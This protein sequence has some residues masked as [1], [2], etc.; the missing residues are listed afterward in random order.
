MTL[1]RKH[2]EKLRV[3][4]A[5]YTKQVD[6]YIAAYPTRPAPPS[7]GY[8][9]LL[10]LDSD[11]P[12]WNDG[13]FTEGNAPWA[14]DRTTQLG[15]RH[16]TCLKRGNEEIHCL[17]WETRRVMRWAIKHHK[18]L[19]LMISLVQEL[20]SGDP[21]DAVELPE[22]LRAIVGHAYIIANDS[23]INRLKRVRVLLHGAYIQIMDLQLAWDPL[24]S[25][26]LSS[27]LP[28][29]E[30]NNIYSSWEHQIKHIHQLHLSNCFSGI[31]GDMN[32]ETL[33]SN[34]TEMEEE[35]LT[36]QPSPN[37]PTPAEDDLDLEEED[38]QQPYLEEMENQLLATMLQDLIQQDES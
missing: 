3:L 8:S 2:A 31:P 14:I 12:F 28:Q 20:L 10:K 33:T 4:L 11:D 17:G 6:K 13:L 16:L 26:I 19:K 5:S 35:M 27:T 22:S 18:K 21:D 7:I 37:P 1:L 29:N 32:D 36:E 23:M 15:I 34:W 24:I 25:K 30:D 9:K 38:G